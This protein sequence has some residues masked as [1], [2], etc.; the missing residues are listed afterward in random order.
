[1]RVRRILAEVLTP[2]NDALAD[3]VGDRTHRAYPVWR[4]RRA[5]SMPLAI[6]GLMSLIGVGTFT[7]LAGIL[8]LTGLLLSEAEIQI[9]TRVRS[10]TTF[11]V[12]VGAFRVAIA[13]LVLVAA[14]TFGW[15]DAPTAA[16][17][18]LVAISTAALL[19]GSLLIA[20]VGTIS[21]LTLAFGLLL[22]LVGVAAPPLAGIAQVA[23]PLVFA[24]GL[25]PI[26]T[27]WT[28]RGVA[29]AH[30]ARMMKDLTDGRV[31]HAE[32]E[33]GAALAEVERLTSH[34][35]REVAVQTRELSERN[36]Y[37]S[38]ASSV[39]FALADSIDDDGAVERAI[40]LIARLLNVRAAQTYR[41][42]EPVPATFITV[43]ADDLDAPR[44][45]DS[46]LRQVAER[47]RF[48]SS[49]DSGDPDWTL[50]DIGVPYV[51]APLVAKG[52]AVGALALI[53]SES[54]VLGEQERNLLLLLG[55][56]IGVVLE[57]CR[58]FDQ[59]IEH[60][61]R[62]QLLAEAMRLM[63]GR[64]SRDEAMREA[65]T[66]ISRHLGAETA[67]LIALPEGVRKPQ[68]V[69][70]TSTRPNGTDE[71]IDRLLRGAPRLISD[72][73]SPMVLGDGGESPLSAEL[74]QRGVGT[75]VL[76]PVIAERNVNGLLPQ[77]RGETDTSRRPVVTRAM[78]GV[79]VLTMGTESGWDAER[80]A[81]VE[82]LAAV[83]SRRMETDELLLLQQRRISELSGLAEIARMMQTGADT[84]RLYSG[85]AQALSSLL[86]YQDLY[87][88][89]L[90]DAGAL[91]EIPSFSAGG[92]SQAPP[93]F[94]AVDG[95]HGWFALRS[96]AAWV[97]LEETLP[98]FVDTEDRVGL[99]VPMRPKGQLLGLVVLGLSVPAQVDQVRIVEQAVEQLA[100]ALDNAALYRQAT[101]RAS[102]IQALSN[103][104]R[105]VA[106][107]VDLREAFDAFAEEVRW[108]I[109]FERAVM[110]LMD[111]QSEMIEPY[112]TYP[113]ESNAR[114]RL[115]PLAGSLAELAVDAGGPVSISRAEA[116]YAD[117]DWDIFGAG[118]QHIAAVPVRH[119]MRTVAVF[120]LVQGGDV[121]YSVN[122]LD[123]LGEVAG[124]L[125]VTIERLRLYEQAEHSAR[126]DALTGLPNYRYLQERLARVRAGISEPGESAVLQIDMDSLKLFN[127]TLGHEA[128]DR[129]IQIVARTLRDSVGE[130]DFVA[131][132]GGDE[133][134]VVME[135]ATAADVRAAAVRM[136]EGLRGAH[137]EF[138]NA[139]C[140]VG[141]SVGVA[142]APIDA[143]NTAELM[144]VA[145]HA[146]YT[147]KF[148]GG[149]RTELAAGIGRGIMPPSR[150]RQTRLLELTMQA[151]ADGASDEDRTTLARAERYLIAIGERL[152]FS[153]LRVM[154]LRLLVAA[155]VGGRVPERSAHPL[156]GRI[157]D[158]F[159][160]G[161]RDQIRD[162][163][164]EIGEELLALP[165]ALV[166]LAW[167]QRVDRQD[168][169]GSLAEQM[170]LLRSHFGEQIREDTLRV[171][172]SVVRE[173]SQSEP[174]VRRAA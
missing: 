98:S 27:W 103:L 7:P 91:S 140:P 120:A 90:D 100:L 166:E 151:C 171:I 144:Q 29:F 136:H 13:L 40:R 118:A 2:N 150:G 75:L 72:R 3:V 73:W 24:L 89:R 164:P 71:T 86:T 46:L 74:A 123:A 167:M 12:V 5:L 23:K 64:G 156:N 49:V 153:E 6:L 18:L 95:R 4:L 114:R 47:G 81:V 32:D 168:G 111:P 173:A 51:I 88:V 94:S 85:F 84:E 165:V 115:W 62:E 96:A 22:P 68:L 148:G 53:G 15:P 19:E 42:G 67:A 41:L 124:L 36:R 16:A 138:T 8:L 169:P 14:L 130:H 101:E 129:V 135:N 10:V 155:E 21:A 61:D 52:A 154:S 121:A 126:H 147:A 127:D 28:R 33:L 93:P 35:E 11:E 26:T 31:R 78:V 174:D 128:G 39:S 102:H 163:Y 133:F 38:I 63:N 56:E 17:L 70:M 55:R 69:S 37:L 82:R 87:I 20:T 97:A 57:H 160:R 125:G 159:V 161:A 34:L 105:I 48:L 139:P 131:R 122:D 106:S 137:L 77:R 162:G 44:L 104:A 134:V 107:V 157:A 83:L 50:P 58:R 54:T 25:L 113:D 132:T 170:Q 9:A 141:I 149:D 99:V 43:P 92:R 152:G 158:A 142:M 30:R 146:M 119:G 108:L 117:Y 60:A 145:D 112:A 59:A 66:L 65:L 110:L 172:E 116:P 109:P 45:P 76:A 80:S 143:D 79:L 1:M